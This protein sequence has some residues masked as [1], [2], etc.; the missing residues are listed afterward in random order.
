MTPEFID[1]PE[2]RREKYPALLADIREATTE[3]NREQWVLLAE[4]GKPGSARD[5]AFRLK[6]LNPLFEF[7]T[8][9]DPE[10]GAGY[11]YVRFVGE[12]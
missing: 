2:D 3:E 4:F 6:G 7:I 1:L 11:L 8:R 10:D 9:S 12:L 5:T